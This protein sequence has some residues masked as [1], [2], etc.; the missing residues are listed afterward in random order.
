MARA[1]ETLSKPIVAP[2]DKITLLPLGGVGKI[3]MNNMLIGCDGHWILLDSGVMF[4]D[5][6]APG[7]DLVLPCLEVIDRLEGTF[8]GVVLTH[9]HEDHIGSL[10]FVRMRHDVKV[11]GTRFTLGLVRARFAEH[12]LSTD[13]LNLVTPGERLQLG[14]F[15]IG[16][17]RVT[18]SIP[19]CVSLA[20]RTPVGNVLFTGDFK[21]DPGLPCGTRFDEAG[22][23]A[24]GQEGVLA[25]MADSTNIQRPGRTVS[26]AT[27][28]EGLK[29]AIGE[30][31]GRVFIGLFSS[32]LYRL[33]S[34]LAAARATNRKVCLLGRSLHKYLQVAKEWG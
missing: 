11:W 23:R 18:H 16:F 19:D 1:L 33:H 7:I 27:V 8:H 13:C 24:F 22:Y 29:A 12:H 9:G 30:A 15:D 5:Q 31:P 17:L 3:G 26:E 4:P 2:A 25:L 20:I 6:R 14:V 34:V 21:I 32:N 28:A 10:P